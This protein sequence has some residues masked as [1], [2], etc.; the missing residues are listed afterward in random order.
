MNSEKLY[1]TNP[2]DNYNYLG[3]VVK[4]S[5]E[6]IK[7]NMY[8]AHVAKNEWG[9]LTV[10][11]RSE[12]LLPICEEFTRR[13]DE[14]A[15]LITLETG[16]P[17]I[18]S[19]G[20]IEGYTEQIYDFMSQAK[21]ALKA[22]DNSFTDIEQDDKII[23]EPKGATAV[24]APWNY[25]YGMAVWGIIPNLLAGNTV[26]FKTSEETPLVGKFIEEVF[27]K[28]QLPDGVFNE[29]YGDSEQGEQLVRSAPD[30]VW[31]TGSTQTGMHINK[32][33][34]E[35]NT[36]TLLEMG[37][38]NPAVIFEDAEIDVSL[39]QIFNNRF[40]NNGQTCDAIKRL[41]VHKDVAPII[42]DGLSSII[43]SSKIG[44][45]LEEDTFFGSLVAKRQLNSLQ[46]AVDESVANGSR[47]ISPLS[48]VETPGGAF[49]KPVLIEGINTVSDSVWRTEMFGPILPIVT[50]EHEIEAVELAND[51]SYGLGA[52]VVSQDEDRA[53]RVASKIK[54][55]SVNI[56]SADHWNNAWNPFGG[57]KMS[58][59]G[60]E[61]GI[62][63]MRQLT[64]IKVI[65]KPKT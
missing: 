30:F 11:Q 14:L 46:Y 29:I 9:L 51:T 4:S 48:N 50:F 58:G 44:N 21:L 61:H 3:V 56:N 65:S 1:S 16:K 15:E 19:K 59:N 24:I 31:F 33:A 10:N 64:N 40:A 55:G 2:A 22:E 42:I 13:S 12:Y 47:I 26:V 8:K 23:Y 63:G 17:I 27:N 62:H 25:P 34:S 52:L 36:P 49:M 57:V 6:E 41:V 37:G 35:T 60:R 45:P 43:E 39:Q 7:H 54:A 28:S 53:L 38:S 18:Q 20:E 5:P 32:I